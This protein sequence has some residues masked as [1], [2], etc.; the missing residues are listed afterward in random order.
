MKKARLIVSDLD[1]TLLS[2][3][4]S[5][6]EE[7][8][9]AIKKARQLGIEFA[10]STGRAYSV[11][12]DVIKQNPNVRY[13]SH[14]NGA[15]IFDKVLGKNIVESVI[16]EQTKRRVLDIL[17]EYDTLLCLHADDVAY[18]EEKM[19]DS[20][21]F[22]RYHV[23][24]AYE[25]VFRN[26][27]ILPDIKE[28]IKKSK[29]PELFITFFS[30]DEELSECKSRL[31]A[32]REITVTSSIEH[33]I[34]ICSGQAGKGRALE[35]LFEILGVSADEVI[36]LGDS[37]NDLEMFEVAGLSVCTA[38]GNAEAKKRATLVGPSNDEHI[39]KYVLEN[40]L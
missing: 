37:T 5:L 13:V 12:P 33:N 36:A 22:K 40:L 29:K 3:D 25:C 1:G 4:K 15:V 18:F 14:S 2:S 6:S 27:K 7:N 34:E 10:V 20:E 19:L 9:K 17:S 38:N 8:S 16:D 35:A 26:M 11:I 32:L 30:S 39:A 23:N 28:F 21:I 31:E 24:E